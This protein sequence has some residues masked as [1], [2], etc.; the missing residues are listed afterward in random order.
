MVNYGRHFI[1]KKDLKSVAETLK[2]D[3]LTQGPKVKT[4]E[5]KI[6]KFLGCKFTL[7]VNSGTAA[8][9]LACISLDLKEGDIVLSTPI[10]FL[11][12]VNATLYLNAKP[13][14]I[15]IDKKNYCIDLNKL[16]KKLIELKKLKKK[17]KILIV[18][19]YAGQMSDWKKIKFLSKKYNFKTINDNCHSLGSKYY[20]DQKYAVKF[21]DVVTHS[22]H[23]VKLITTGEGGCLSTNNRRIYEKV[24]NLRSHGVVRSENLKKKFGNWFYSMEK[25]G[26]N[27][28]MPDINASL[29][30]SQLQKIDKFLKRRKEI[31]KLYYKGFEK[32]KNIILPFIEKYCD[33]SFHLFA[34]Q[35]NFKKIK[36]NKKKFFKLMLEKNINLQV[37]YIPIYLQKYY[38]KKFKYKPNLCPVAESFYKNT[39]SLPVYFSLKKGQVLK[40]INHINKLTS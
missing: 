2:S 6:K 36:I 20:K 14:F 4:F 29:G 32:N 35:I 16:E 17:I 21:A 8:L 39:F 22:F 10:T 25:L 19:D 30:I 15:D 33:H 38:R 9:H 12:S 5:S 23:P 34:I 13:I 7:A 37:H 28:R 3:W 1:D 11:S 31:A 18:T 27:Y 24:L 26:Y 40:T